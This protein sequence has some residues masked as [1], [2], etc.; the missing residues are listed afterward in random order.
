MF[1]L[2]ETEIKHLN[3]IREAIANGLSF[4]EILKLCE[5]V[6][7]E[8][9]DPGFAYT[10][11]A[12]LL[13]S[14]DRIDDA[15]QMFRFDKQDTF[16]SII[17]DYLNDVKAFIMPGKV[18]ESAA[19]YDIYIQTKLYQE[20]QAGTVKN[21]YTFAKNNPPPDTNSTVTILDIGPGNGVLTAQFV[22][23]IALLYNIKKVKLIFV[24]PFEDML[25]TASKNC[26]NNIT[27]DCETVNICCKIQDITREQIDLIKQNTPVWFI[28]AAIS[29]H[30]MPK[31][32]KIP[33]LTL[34]KEFSPNFIL[35]EVNWNHDL[36]EKDSPELIY[37]VAKS[38]GYFSKDILELPVS[39]EDKKLCL[40]HFPVAEAINIIKQDRPNRIDYHTPIEEWQNIGKE[41]GFEVDDAL[42]TYMVDGKPF[43]FVMV[44]RCKV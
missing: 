43:V 44:F 41:A 29:V 3:K 24:D 33:M 13:A 8:L 34:M 16:C 7:I 23:K 32:Q 37:S 35:T 6:K 17:Y 10:Y 12:C 40:Y 42:P 28:N 2:K 5:A 30:H 19:P 22:N 4:D 18:F 9:D 38:Y 20:H 36:P 27:I 39:D 25:N 26:K 11:V 14:R 31:E 15:L 21:I 1:F